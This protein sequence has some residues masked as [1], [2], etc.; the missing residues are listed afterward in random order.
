MSDD[1]PR[2]DMA[3]STLRFIGAIAV[4]GDGTRVLDGD[5]DYVSASFARALEREIA[6]LKR[7]EFICKRCGIRKDADAS[8]Q[9]HGF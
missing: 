1:T 5:F 3:A 8:G 4:P 2:T 7:G 9:D 6:A